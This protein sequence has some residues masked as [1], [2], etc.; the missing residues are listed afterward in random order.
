MTEVPHLER[1][2]TGGYGH[3][4]TSSGSTTGLHATEKAPDQSGGVR[5]V[6]YRRGKWTSEEEAY[7]NRLIHEFKLGVLPLTDGTTLRTFLSKLLNCD[8][9]RISKKFVG[10]NCIGKQVFRRRPSELDKLTEDQLQRTRQELSELERLFLER[11]AQ[12]NRSQRASSGLVKNG[13]MTYGGEGAPP[14]MR[15]PDDFDSQHSSE[16]SGLQG[17]LSNL[18]TMPQTVDGSD[19]HQHQQPT[20]GMG[21]GRGTENM[22]TRG[23]ETGHNTQFGNVSIGGGA[24]PVAAMRHSHHPNIKNEN[25]NSD[26]NGGM[27]TKRGRD[28]YNAINSFY[29]PTMLSS[30]LQSSYNESSH[31]NEKQH[32]QGHSV[33]TMPSELPIGWSGP[34]AGVRLL[35]EDAAAAAAAAASMT[36]NM[37]IPAGIPPSDTI[38]T[39]NRP[40]RAVGCAQNSAMSSTCGGAGAGAGPG[41]P[42]SGVKRVNSLELF[43]FSF[44]EQAV[45]SISRNQSQ[46]DQDTFDLLTRLDQ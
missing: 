12:T 20:P 3:L 34:G 28:D 41:K 42:K 27:T 8:P 36:N 30:T 29:D 25:E 21:I 5:R 16:R 31:Q 1:E 2:G 4:L 18:M 24:L 14:W 11:V 39:R 17:P 44:D 37:Q 38:E 19:Q 13:R 46:H 45:N 32:E 15:P 35:E 10:Q 7:A 33:Q 22:I 26:S 23:F 9:M 6:A 43:D 40:K